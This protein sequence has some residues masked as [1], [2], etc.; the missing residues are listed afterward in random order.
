MSTTYA[1][2]EGGP[3][4]IKQLRGLGGN[5]LKN[6]ATRVVR[7]EMRPILVASRSK[8]P[9]DTGRLRASLAQKVTNNFRRGTVSSLVGSRR[10]F[11][12]R[13]TSGHK[14]VSGRGAVRDK[15]IAKGHKQD[16]GS[17]NWYAGIIEFGKDSKGRIRRK[18]GPAAMLRDPFQA[19]ESKM[20]SNV[21]SEFRRYLESTK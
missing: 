6:V 9:V 15:A 8:T 10:D 19:S 11:T 2:V 18:A 12:F 5:K 16:Q 17:P 3:E 21:S 13:S 4:L 20:I 14:L 7:A 1:R